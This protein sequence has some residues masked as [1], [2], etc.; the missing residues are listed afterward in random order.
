MIQHLLHRF[1][2]HVHPLSGIGISSIIS[3]GGLQ[4]TVGLGHMFSPIQD[5][6]G[7]PLLLHSQKFSQKGSILLSPTFNVIPSNSL[8]CDTGG[9]GC[10]GGAG[11]G[12]I[13]SDGHLLQDFRHSRSMN[14]G[15]LVHWPWL[16]I[17]LQSCLRSLHWYP[18]INRHN[19]ISMLTPR[20]WKKSRWE[21]SEFQK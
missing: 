4:V 6:R 17:H 1:T 13:R 9:A 16:T 15:C 11:C 5:T 8:Q 7:H 20:V 2:L 21:L 14:R 10:D 3:M 19:H 18:W 12:E